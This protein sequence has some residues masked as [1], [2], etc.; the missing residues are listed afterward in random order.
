[1]ALYCSTAHRVL[2]FLSVRCRSF[3]FRPQD[4]RAANVRV[5]VGAPASRPAAPPSRSTKG[6]LRASALEHASA[7]LSDRV[8]RKTGGPLE[9]GLGRER[10]GRSGLENAGSGHWACE[11]APVRQA[12]TCSAQ[13]PGIRVERKSEAPSPTFGELVSAGAVGRKDG[14]WRF[15]YPPYLAKIDASGG[16][17]G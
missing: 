8:E 13:C 4:R 15:A 14:G 9:A 6:Q 5:G 1:M 10:T 7:R 17:Q 3:R 2:S 16:Y 12:H 11:P